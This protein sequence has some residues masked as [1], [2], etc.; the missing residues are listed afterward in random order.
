VFKNDYGAV[1]E[2]WKVDLIVLRARRLG[3]R[4]QDL[5][6]AQQ[7]IVVALL[8]FTFDPQRSN[9]ATEE[10]AVTALID[11][12]LLALRRARERYASRVSGS[13]EDLRNDQVLAVDCDQAKHSF[14][15]SDVETAMAGMSP[16]A[17]EVCNSLADGLSLNEIS[18]QM[19]VGW[20]TVER[21]VRSIRQCFEQV[22]I[23]D[24]LVK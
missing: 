14:V 5:E 7:Q 12:Q 3:F 11:H 24:A 19:G 4:R 2:K 15:A 22:G 23:H 13:D 20:H 18:R 17:R 1:I 8:A 9:G 16:A 6:D 10:T 21:Q